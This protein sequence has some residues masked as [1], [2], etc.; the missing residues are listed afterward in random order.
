MSELSLTEKLNHFRASQENFLSLS[1]S[2]IMAWNDHAAL[3]HYNANPSCDAVIWQEGLL[4][5]YSGS[6]Y[7]EGTTDITRTISTGKP[8]E[9]QKKDFTLVLKGLISLANAVFP[10]GTTGT[11]LDILARKALWENG[12]NYG[13]GTGHGVGFCLNVHEG[14]Q[15]IGPS[16]ASGA[17]SPMMPGMLVSDEPGVYRDGEYGIRSENLLL[18]YEHEETESGKFLK[19]ETMSLCY[20]DRGLISASLLEKDEIAWLN[21]YHAI[22]Y[23][24]LS[25][26]LTK[27][28][29]LWL[30]EK[31]NP[32]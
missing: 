26:Y 12:I 21:S 1:F 30:K 27:E 28:E 3:P 2:T 32:F 31:T 9:K 4:L 8:S 6:H 24:K 5:V 22:V 18:C 7:L 15:N 23:E 25:P 16:A 17:K 19:F 13:H 11:Q 10:E 20:F 14:P 29:N